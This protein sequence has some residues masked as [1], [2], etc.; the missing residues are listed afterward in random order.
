MDQ[1]MH[2]ASTED[3][4]RIRWRG[5]VP[6]VGD[7]VAAGYT[8]DLQKTRRFTVRRVSW[9]I[10]HGWSAARVVLWEMRDG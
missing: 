2:E 3:G 4:F 1:P 8:S 6:S 9:V 5:E 7:M 10:S